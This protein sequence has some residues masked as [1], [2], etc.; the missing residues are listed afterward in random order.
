M[1]EENKKPRPGPQ[2]QT[3][4]VTT[5]SWGS[6]HDF[7]TQLPDASW[8]LPDKFWA[9]SEHVDRWNSNGD[10]GPSG[11]TLPSP[12]MF[13]KRS[14]TVWNT[15]NRAHV[16]TLTAVRPLW[17][18]SGWPWLS[19]SPIVNSHCL[20]KTGRLHLLGHR[21]GTPPELTLVLPK[22]WGSPTWVG[23]CYQGNQEPSL[24][25]LVSLIKEPKNKLKR[26][27]KDNFVSV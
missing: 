8:T 25:V 3:W 4:L 19:F 18:T 13:S 20:Y 6:R 1:A 9:V 21:A 5:F 7:D 10:Q 23:T 16:S 12:A 22:I 17:P 15:G 2:T 11:P 27:P 26:K 24:G 14:M